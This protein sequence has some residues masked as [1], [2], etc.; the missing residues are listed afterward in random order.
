MTR[1]HQVHAPGSKHHQ[2]GHHQHGTHA[3]VD[4]EKRVGWAA[5]LTAAYMLAEAAGGLLA[6]SLALLAD[7]G[8][9]LTDAASLA[10]AWAAFRIARRPPT[11]N[12]P[13][14]FIAFR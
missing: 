12:A 1:P 3:H 13:M 11:G 2:H 5:V 4:N 8:H 10:L 7:A 6:G 9:M 14:A